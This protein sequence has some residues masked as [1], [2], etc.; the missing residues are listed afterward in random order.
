MNSLGKGLL[1]LFAAGT[2]VCADVPKLDSLDELLAQAT[3]F[4][5]SLSLTRGPKTADNDWAQMGAQIQDL[6]AA[7]QAGS[8]Q[9]A[10][11]LVDS[12]YVLKQKMPDCPG[13]ISVSLDPSSEKKN[14]ECNKKDCICLGYRADKASTPP[15]L[16]QAMLTLGSLCAKFF[17]AHPEASY[18]ELKPHLVQTL[19]V[20]Q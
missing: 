7:L 12:I 11:Q 19:P 13:N 1:C 5:V 14:N 8:L 17:A 16:W 2:C 20:D 6:A 4:E 15:T 18:Q 10:F 3:S 9:K